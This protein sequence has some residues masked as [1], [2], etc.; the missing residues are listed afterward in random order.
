MTST[1]SLIDLPDSMEF[2]VDGP[3]D[4]QELNFIVETGQEL[5]VGEY[6]I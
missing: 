5:D 2:F 3:L 1:N 4:N 6:V